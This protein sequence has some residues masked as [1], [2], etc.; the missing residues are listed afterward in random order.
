MFQWVLTLV[1][2]TFLLPIIHDDNI[3]VNFEI[4]IERRTKIYITY[5]FIYH[6]AFYRILSGRKLELL[7]LNTSVLRMIVILNAGII[8]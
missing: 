8:H 3:K 2:Y 6:V 5:S 7:T 1:A 4:K